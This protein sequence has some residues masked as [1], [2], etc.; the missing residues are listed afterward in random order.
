M[1]IFLGLYFT[2]ISSIASNFLIKASQDVRL[3]FL[4]SPKVIQ[5]VQTI[6]LTEII[7]IF[8]ICMKIL[9]VNHNIHPFGLIVLSILSAYI[10]F[11]FWF[12]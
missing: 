8:Y 1:G 9:F 2:A 12:V 6:V 7:G 11:R 3:F 4:F 5:Y 10:I